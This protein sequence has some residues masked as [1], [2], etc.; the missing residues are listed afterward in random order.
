MTSDIC[1]RDEGIAVSGHILQREHKCSGI[2]CAHALTGGKAIQDFL[3]CLGTLIRTCTPQNPPAPAVCHGGSLLPAA[4]LRESFEG[5]CGNCCQSEIFG[6]DPAGVMR[7]AGIIHQPDTL[8]SSQGCSP[9]GDTHALHRFIGPLTDRLK[10]QNTSNDY[11]G[12]Q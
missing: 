10:Q 3:G 2:P 8:V 11:A 7:S 6:A 1:A 5:K 12:C 4:R 9:D